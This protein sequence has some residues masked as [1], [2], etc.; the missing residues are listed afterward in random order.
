MLVLVEADY[1]TYHSFMLEHALLVHNTIITLK[2]SS[3]TILSRDGDS[4][5]QVY[6]QDV[7][8]N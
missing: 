8:L 3:I 6:A 2:P 4:G 1:A 5:R 7:P